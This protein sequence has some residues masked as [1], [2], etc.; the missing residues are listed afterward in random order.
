MRRLTRLPRSLWPD[1]DEPPM[2]RNC[3]T[4]SY[5]QRHTRLASAFAVLLVFR[6]L[7]V[8]NID[9]VEGL[10]HR[11]ILADQCCPNRYSARARPPAASL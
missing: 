6:Q 5:V 1:D 7:L 10:R 9:P 3:N 11:G 2:P 4:Q 8:D